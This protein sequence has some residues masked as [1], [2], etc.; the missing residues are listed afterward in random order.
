MET[1]GGA[2]WCM[3]MHGGAWDA[4]GCMAGHGDAWRR[5]ETY[6][7][8]WWFMAVHGDAG[9]CRGAAPVVPLATPHPA[10]VRFRGENGQ[11]GAATAGVRS[12][13]FRPKK[14]KIDNFHT[15]RTKNLPFWRDEIEGVGREAR[16]E[17]SFPQD[18]A[19]NHW[20]AHKRYRG[21]E[22]PEKR[23]P[24][25]PCTWQLPWRVHW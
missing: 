13:G 3:G 11:I 22:A 15:F 1:H 9:R 21:G 12:R 25:I 10:R 14:C 16:C 5:M 17:P 4:W 20:A 7:G 6:G 19:R 18:P 23:T 2:W 24:P 8:A